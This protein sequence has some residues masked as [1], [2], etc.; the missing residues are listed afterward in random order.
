MT[1]TRKLGRPPGVDGAD[2]TRLILDEAER[3]FASVGYAM[4]TNK[5]VA[6]ACGLTTAALYHYFG[7]KP[8]LYAAVS[9]QVHPSMLATFEQA[10]AETP[11][12]LRARLKA[13]LEAS[14]VL[15]RDRP[16]LAGFVMGGPVEAR[17]HPELRE[18]VDHHFGQIETLI[19]ALVAEARAGGELRPERAIDDVA[20]MVLSVLHGFAHLAYRDDSV[21]RF[22]R[23]IR[24]FEALLDGALL[25]EHSA[26]Q[27]SANGTAGPVTAQ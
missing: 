10:L 2:T 9:A 8:A 7:T 3:Q 20:G 16:S 12:T 27:D 4:T 15:H 19:E 1:R 24:S 11:P 17:R 14:V 26:V 5:T 25:T 23:V 22:E 18:V 21:E 13:I 6:D